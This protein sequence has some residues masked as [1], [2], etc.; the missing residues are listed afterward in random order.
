MCTTNLFKN[1]ILKQSLEL[2]PWDKS[3]EADPGAKG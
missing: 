3:P 1:K 2:L